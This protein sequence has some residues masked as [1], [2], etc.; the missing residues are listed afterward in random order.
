[1]IDQTSRFGH[2]SP[3]QEDIWRSHYL[4]PSQ[5]HLNMYSAW[6]LHEDVNIQALQVAFQ[7]LI[8]RYPTL[9]TKFTL[10]DGQ[11]FQS[12]L[13]NK[14]F[15]LE[16]YDLSCKTHKEFNQ[17]LLKEANQPFDL[18][19]GEMLKAILYQN[20]EKRKILLF[21][22]HHLAIDGWSIVIMMKE[23]GRL[24]DEHI[25][26]RRSQFNDSSASYLTFIE[27]QMKRIDSEYERDMLRYWSGDY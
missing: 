20:E 21:N 4:S 2:L 14:E 6:S 18:E 7:G 1:M 10:I 17:I 22:F 26:G 13:P 27:E 16:Y 19:K 9:R 25:S 8:R 23:F 15:K 3:N 5:N 12:I 24:Y 11:P